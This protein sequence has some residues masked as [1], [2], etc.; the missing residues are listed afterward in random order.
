MKDM[1]STP[2]HYEITY[3][4]TS[5]S[6]IETSVTTNTES[7]K[8][9]TPST[10]TYYLG[11]YKG[12]EAFDVV[13]DFQRDSYNLGV[14]IAYLLRAGKKQG[15]PRGQDIS[16]AIDHLKKEL[17]YERDFGLA[18]EATENNIVK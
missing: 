11:K 3:S 10:P 12:L 13:M 14:A 7:T 4:S 17:E 18:T 2:S 15:N 16:K 9:N 6:P 5:E 1:K 8:K